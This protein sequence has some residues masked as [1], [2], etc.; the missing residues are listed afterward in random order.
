MS[1]EAGAPAKRV[2][3]LPIE[4]VLN[5]N[6]CAVVSGEAGAPAK[7]VAALP[8]EGVLNPNGCAVVSGEA[9]WA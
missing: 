6:G 9:R 3:A 5:P 8:I 4:G 7:R 1:G 2:A